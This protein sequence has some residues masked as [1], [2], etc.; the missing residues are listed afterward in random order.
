VQIIS[1]LKPGE[2]VVT[3]GQFL[4]DSEAKMREA[5]AKM[6]EGDLA[7]DQPVSA[8]VAG[9]AEVDELPDDVAQQLNTA[10][11]HYLAIGDTLAGDTTAGLADHAQPLADALDGL[12]RL[13][14][15]ADPQLWHKH[16]DAIATAR[17]N[18][19]KLVEV[20]DLA[21]ARLRFGELSTSLQTLLM[22]TGVPPGFDREVHVLHCP[23]YRG[24]Q[25]GTIWLQAAGDVRNPYFGASML[26][27]F[28]RRQALPVTGGERGGE[29]EAGTDTTDQDGAK[30]QAAGK[31]DYPIDFCLVSGEPLGS[32]GQPVTMQYEGRTVKFCCDACIIS[33]Q[34]NPDEY[35]KKLDEAAKTLG[36]TRG[37]R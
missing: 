5:L 36:K 18:A 35:L 32:M 31:D 17:A 23:M 28:D 34:T 1:G 7:A 20:D 29:A 21:D 12:V 26:E 22:A 3:S 37:G 14:V 8:D 10:L 9:A 15:P 13:D 11:D 24:G 25:G 6:I 27:C 16:Q 2:M 4:I 19:F 33:F 30:P